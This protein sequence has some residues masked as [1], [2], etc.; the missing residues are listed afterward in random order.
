VPAASGPAGGVPSGMPATL[1]T[2]SLD[3]TGG[4]LWA[5][6]LTTLTCLD[7]STGRLLSSWQPAPS[8]L[9]VNSVVAAGPEIYG[10]TASGIGL[11]ESPTACRLAA[12]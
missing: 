10:V 2:V 9:S 4:T 12:G 3:D 1:E 6:D 7:S 11:L 5:A 8:S